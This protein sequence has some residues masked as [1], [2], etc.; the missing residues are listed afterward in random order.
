MWI[1]CQ[2]ENTGGLFSTWGYAYSHTDQ[3]Q[4]VIFLKYIGQQKPYY[5]PK[6]AI[7]FKFIVNKSSKF[8]GA[9]VFAF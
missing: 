2:F 6:E 8:R 1:S 3:T 9:V 7:W 4:I 5:Q